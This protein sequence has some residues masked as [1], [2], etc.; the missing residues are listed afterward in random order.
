MAVGPATLAV[1]L[2]LPGPRY[3]VVL[4]IPYLAWLLVRHRPP[5]TWLTAIPVLAGAL[6]LG[7]LFSAYEHML[8]A[9]AVEFAIIVGSAWAAKLIAFRR[10]RGT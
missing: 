10:S 4:V 9:L 8:G 3:L 1:W 5:L 6:V 7:Q 2:L